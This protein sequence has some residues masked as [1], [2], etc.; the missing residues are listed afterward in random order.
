MTEQF[1]IGEESQKVSKDSFDAVVRS[2]GEAN[3][4]YQAI[5]AE[6]TDYCKK[7]FEYA[8]RTLEQLAGVKSVEQVIEIQSQYAKK[9]YDDYIAEATKLSEMYVSL[10]RSAYKPL[11]TALAKKVA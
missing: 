5:V 6:F 8:S 4:G 10:T 1:K 11:Q 9:V 2:Y 7:A 3:K